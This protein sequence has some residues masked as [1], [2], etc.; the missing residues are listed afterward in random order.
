MRQ[1]QSVQTTLAKFRCDGD[2]VAGGECGVR[3]REGF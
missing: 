1:R 2:G 3:G